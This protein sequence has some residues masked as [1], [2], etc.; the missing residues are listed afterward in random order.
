MNIPRLSRGIVRGISTIVRAGSAG[1]CAVFAQQGLSRGRLLGPLPPEGCIDI[2]Y[3]PECYS[4]NPLT[5]C[6]T[7]RHEVRCTECHPLFTVPLDGIFQA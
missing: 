3:V 4:P 2:L 7:T 1:G 5:E 6:C